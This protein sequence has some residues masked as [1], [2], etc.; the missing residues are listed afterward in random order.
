[1]FKI[2]YKIWEVWLYVSIVILVAFLFVGTLEGSKEE[3]PNWYL[4]VMCAIGNLL[5]CVIKG[6]TT[7]E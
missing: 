6:A 3:Y 4:G 2:S 7:K 5:A 1:M